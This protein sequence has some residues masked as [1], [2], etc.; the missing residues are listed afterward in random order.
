M[1]KTTIMT[2]KGQEIRVT[3]HGKPDSQLVKKAY[4]RLISDILRDYEDKERTSMTSSLVA[5]R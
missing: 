2:V 1:I 3:Q 5:E 4:E